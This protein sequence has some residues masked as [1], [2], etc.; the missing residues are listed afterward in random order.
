M[1][2]GLVA[3]FGSYGPV[4]ALSALPQNLTQTFAS[5]DRVLDLLEEKP[6]VREIKDGKNFSF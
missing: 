5:G 4:I 2:M 3:I 6:V 1:I